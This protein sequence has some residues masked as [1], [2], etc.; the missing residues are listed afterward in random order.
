MPL[1]STSTNEALVILR[2]IVFICPICIQPSTQIAR[3]SPSVTP[4]QAH[5]IKYNQT[6][7]IVYG[8]LSFKPLA[9]C[10]V[11]DICR[12]SPLLVLARSRR[13]E[14]R[15]GG[16]VGSADAA[17]NK[18]IRARNETTLRRRQK[19]HRVGHLASFAETIGESKST[20]KAK[21]CNKVGLESVFKLLRISLDV[22]KQCHTIKP[23]HIPNFK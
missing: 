12:N 3:L 11:R 19:H 17:V 2:L 7:I 21:V 10:V 8:H 4:Y 9:W 16:D 15:V 13:L 22:K 6:Q 18:K 1:T 20:S 5:L 23:R 14:G